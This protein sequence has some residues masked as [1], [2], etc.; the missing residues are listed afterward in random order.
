M[1][2]PHSRTATPLDCALTQRALDLARHGT[3]DFA[4]NVLRVPLGYYRDPDVLAREQHMLR[5]IPLAIVPSSQIASPNDYVVRTVLGTSLL[6][7]RDENGQAHVLLNYCR[8]RGA[9]PVEGCGNQRRH[10]C[11]Y[12]AWTY[13]AAGRLVHVPNDDGFAGIDRSGYGLVA[14]PSEERHGFV[15]AALTTDVPIDVATHLGELDDELAS[16]HYE[17]YGYL[18]EREFDSTVNW[19]GALEAFAESYHFPFVHGR[20]LIGRSTLANTSVHDTYGR[21]HRLGFPFNWITALDADPNGSWDPLDQMG[22]IYWIFPN[23]IL[24][25]SMVGVEIID[26]LPAGDPTACTVRHGWLAR[27]PATNDDERAAYMGIYEQV[28]AA[29]R[30]E[31]FAMLPACGDGVRQ[32]QH[33]HMLI[34]RNEVGVQHMVRTLAASIGM[35]IG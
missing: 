21:H 19:K 12:H 28:H 9:R 16:F 17:N 10:S 13:D 5:R 24:A 32:G 15:W 22:V 6:V 29:V 30:D 8:H 3:T 33:E 2:A 27:I 20:S 34:G 23:L 1:I 25:N 18:T 4:P 11:P 14:L 35:E 7:T 26:I 31:D